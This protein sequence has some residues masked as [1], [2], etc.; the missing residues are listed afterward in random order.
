MRIDLPQSRG[1]EASACPRMLQTRARSNERM[2]ARKHVRTHARTQDSTR[3][4]SCSETDPVTRESTPNP[5][6]FLGLVSFD[7]LGWCALARVGWT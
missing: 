6:Q 7:N 3:R 1:C 2:H 5:S 4:S